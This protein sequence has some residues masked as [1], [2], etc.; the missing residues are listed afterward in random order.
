MTTGK[1]IA[2]IGG[3]ILAF[4]IIAWLALRPKAAIASVPQPMP[5]PNNNPSLPPTIKTASGSM[6]STIDL[7]ASQVY[8]PKWGTPI[9]VTTPAEQAA[10]AAAKKHGF[11]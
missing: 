10:L 1:K 9:A 5:M 2:V 7:P 11:L 3:S 6:V 4:G 8:Q